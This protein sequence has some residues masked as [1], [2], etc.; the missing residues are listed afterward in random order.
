EVI[1]AGNNGLFHVAYHFV[2][3]SPPD[4]REAVLVEEGKIEPSKLTA[5]RLQGNELR[6]LT[7]LAAAVGEVACNVKQIQWV[8][9]SCNRIED[10]KEALKPF[11]ELR[12]LNLHGNSIKTFLGLKCLSQRLPHLRSITLHGNPVTE[13]KHYRNYVLHTFPSITQFD[14]GAIAKQD[15]ENAKTWAVTFRKKLN[16]RLLEDA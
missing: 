13:N 6:D 16:P 4:I 3:V 5:L 2:P 14:F 8:D 11:E 15:R 1:L 7:S 10:I 9:L 12:V